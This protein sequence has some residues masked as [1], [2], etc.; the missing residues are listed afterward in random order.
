[1]GLRVWIQVD[2]SCLFFID[3]VSSQGLKLPL[4][5]A[6]EPLLI[7]I[8]GQA[9]PW[10]TKEPEGSPAQHWGLRR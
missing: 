2:P 10:E 3:P 4:Q 5:V 6:N 7:S 8:P 1:M 9:L